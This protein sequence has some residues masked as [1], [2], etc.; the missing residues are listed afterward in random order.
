MTRS[1]RG[2]AF[3]CVLL[4]NATLLHS[5]WAQPGTGEVESL[6]LSAANAETEQALGP[7]SVTGVPVPGSPLSQAAN[8]DVVESDT[9]EAK[10]AT[11]LGEA[12]DD[13]AGVNSIGTGNSVGKP[14]IRGLSGERIKILSNGVGMDH[15]QYGVRH[16]PTT[17]TFLLG[18]AEVVRG[19][20]SVLY[21]SSALGG[22]INLL[23]PDIA[24]DTPIEG[25]TLTRYST[26]NNQWG[27]G[28]QG[29]WRQ[30]PLRLFR[31]HYP[32]QRG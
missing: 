21:G 28:R 8:V 17:E 14:V 1:R 24:W 12:L 6:D 20:S 32:P 29:Q 5:S 27:Y 15:Q 3:A 10:G 25:E 22:A 4:A 13:L 19:A 18:R 16:M 11:N 23:P 26:N 9:I 30:R 31:R 2:Q 7:I